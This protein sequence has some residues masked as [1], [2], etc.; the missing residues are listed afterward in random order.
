MDDVDFAAV[1][2]TLQENWE[3]FVEFSGGEE[4]ADLTLAALK[5]IGGLD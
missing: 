4:S 3:S 1:V 2:M 5:K